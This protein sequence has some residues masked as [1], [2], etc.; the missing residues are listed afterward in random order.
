MR[1]S[2]TRGLAWSEGLPAP[3]RATWLETKPARRVG[4]SGASRGPDASLRA[5]AAWR[6]S[7]YA[8]ELQCSFSHLFRVR[9][10]VRVRVRARVSG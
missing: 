4:K 8:A 7:R 2:A 9:I 3:R 6:E 10:R 5:A 1:L